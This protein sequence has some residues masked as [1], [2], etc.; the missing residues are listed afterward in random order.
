MSFQECKFWT[1]QTVCFQ[2]STKF[3]KL[4]VIAM[5][6]CFLLRLS[7]QPHWGR[8][9]SKS[10]LVLWSAREISQKGFEWILKNKVFNTGK[11]HRTYV[12]TGSDFVPMCNRK[13]RLSFCFLKISLDSPSLVSDSEFSQSCYFKGNT[14]VNTLHIQYFIWPN[15]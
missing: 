1:G 6:S 14:Y 4:Y 15:F 10:H 12:R 8:I 3:Q 11:I 7:S 13:Q 2:F 9:L 5:C